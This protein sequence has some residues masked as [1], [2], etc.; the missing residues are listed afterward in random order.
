MSRPPCGTVK[1]KSNNA[2]TR[3]ELI[4]MYR[5]T[6]AGKDKSIYRLK[7]MKMTDLCIALG[8]EEEI[9]LAKLYKAQRDK[10]NKG[11]KSKKAKSPELSPSSKPKICAR[12]S[13]KRYNVYKKQELVDMYKERH[14]HLTKKSIKE[15]SIQSL[16]DQFPEIKN[17]FKPKKA[18][19]PSPLRSRSG[20]SLSPSPLRSRSS[21]SLSP[22]PLRSRSSL[23]LSPSPLRSRSGLSLSPSPLR[24]R[25]GLSL[26]PSQEYSTYCEDGRCEGSK[27]KS[28]KKGEKKKKSPKK[29]KEDEEMNPQTGRCRKKCKDGEER[30]EKGKCKGE[31]KEKGEKKKKSPKKCKDDEERNPQTG[32]CRKKCKDGEERDKNGKCRRK[33]YENMNDFFKDFYQRAYQPLDD[34]CQTLLKKEGITDLKTYRKWTV[35]NHPDKLAQML[36]RGEMSQE[37]IEK[38]EQKIRRVNDCVDRVYKS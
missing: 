15:M 23:S 7:T 11:K 10:S 27:K 19:S 17:Q 21:L 16:C 30:D 9:V 29:C 33:V 35:L 37:E 14:P 31:K 32:K 25:S 36:N 1:N 18:K 4:D 20:L 28:P 13:T 38:M 34:T 12:R 24:S 3:Q 6:E 2:Y 22:S 26:S 5:Q 8:M